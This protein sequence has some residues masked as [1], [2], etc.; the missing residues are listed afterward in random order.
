MRA[1]R[2]LQLSYDFA[3]CVF[4]GVFF[5]NWFLVLQSLLN[6]LADNCALTV[7]QYDKVVTYLSNKRERQVH[8]ELGESTANIAPITRTSQ[9]KTL[10]LALPYS[11][12]SDLDQFYCCI[13]ELNCGYLCQ[14]TRINFY[15]LNCVILLESPSLDKQAELQSRIM[16]ILSAKNAPSISSAVSS[17]VAALSPAAAPAPVPVPVPV[18]ALSVSSGISVPSNLG[19]IMSASSVLSSVSTPSSVSTGAWNPPKPHTDSTTPILSDPNVQKALDSLMQGNL[20]QRLVGN[21]TSSGPTIT[22][23]T[24]SGNAQTGPLFSAYANSGTNSNHVGGRRF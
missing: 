12:Q 2:L 1:E 18:P 6:L 10:F 16:S 5:V 13:L 24:L 14:T 4:F 17:A 7:L 11:L 19:S 23:S 20:L 15:F 21:N 9:G 3:L 8:I 22:S